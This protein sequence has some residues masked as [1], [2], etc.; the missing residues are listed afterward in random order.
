MGSFGRCARISKIGTHGVVLFDFDI[1]HS[2]VWIFIYFF[3][4]DS[5][6]VY[7]YIRVIDVNGTAI[8]NGNRWKNKINKKRWEESLLLILCDAAL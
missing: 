6:N 4:H 8:R 3:P 7:T 1:G 2:F 5:G